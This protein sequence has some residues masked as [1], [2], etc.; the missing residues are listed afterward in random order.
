MGLRTFGA[1]ALMYGA[2]LIACWI[3]GWH[4]PAPAVYAALVALGLL[5]GAWLAW[6]RDRERSKVFSFLRIFEVYCAPP[7]TLFYASL[8]AAVSSV[9]GA[10]FLTAVMYDW[11]WRIL[12]S[13]IGAAYMATIPLQLLGIHSMLTTKLLVGLA[14]IELAIPLHWRQVELCNVTFA[15]IDPRGLLLGVRGEPSPVQV[16]MSREAADRLAALVTERTKPV[17]VPTM[18]ARGHRTVDQW[19]RDLTTVDYRTSS[20]DV[21]TLD[22][23]LN[24]G[25]CSIEER[26]GAALMLAAAGEHERVKDAAWSM[27]HYDT[28]NALHAVARQD[29][30]RWLHRLFDEGGR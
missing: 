22:R 15:R 1:V 14:A 6:A 29:P 28:A 18:L 25:V 16:P 7:G 11:T 2:T 21:D 13:L 8:I 19:K 27:V 3:Y 4:A 10:G 12:A 30:D 23:V 5:M 26:M 20:I 17:D 24:A 9:V